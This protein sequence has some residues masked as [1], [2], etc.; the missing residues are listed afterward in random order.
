MFVK[1]NGD[2]IGPDVYSTTV[3]SSSVINGYTVMHCKATATGFSA[4]YALK[5]HQTNPAYAGD[6]NCMEILAQADPNDRNDPNYVPV[7]NFIPGII[8]AN[9][10]KQ[11]Y[12]GQRDV[13]PFPGN[14]GVPPLIY[15][16][17]GA[18]Y[19]YGFFDCDWTD[20]S[21]ITHSLNPK[22]NFLVNNPP[23]SSYS[24]YD[25]LSNGSRPL[26]KERYVIHASANMWKAFGLMTNNPSTYRDEL[27]N[28]VFFDDW[29]ASFEIGKF[30]LNWLK[31][32][33]A[34]KMN[35]Y[36]VVEGW[37]SGGFDD[38]DPDSYRIPDHNQPARQFGTKNQ[39]LQYITSG[40]NAG[41][42]GLRCNY[43][44]AA[45]NSWSIQ[46]G[47]V[48]K[49]LNSN[50]VPQ[51]FTDFNSVEPLVSSQEGDI[52]TDFN[53]TAVFHD[54]W[55][56]GTPVNLNANWIGAEC[57]SAT[58]RQTI[59]RICQSAK[60]THGGPMGSESLFMEYLLGEYVD[61]GDFDVMNADTRY[62][63]VPEYKLYRLHQ[64]S[65]FHGMGL[66]HRFFTGVDDIEAGN[67]SYFMDD[68]KLDGYRACEVLYGNGGYLFSCAYPRYGLREIHALTE[69]FT[70][71]VVQRYYALQQLDYMQYGKAGQWKT[72]DQ[73]ITSSSTLADVQSWFK[74]FHVRYTNGCHVWVNRDTSNLA[75]TLPDSN[76]VTLPQNGWLV[77]TEDCNVVAYTALSA[78][79]DPDPN[80]RVDFCND[81]NRGI[82][83]VNPRTASSYKGVNKPTVWFNNVIHF[84]LDDSQKTFFEDYRT[85]SA[86]A[87]Y[88]GGILCS[89]DSDEA[90]IYGLELNGTDSLELHTMTG[91]GSVFRYGLGLAY[92]VV[93]GSVSGYDA[94]LETTSSSNPTLYLRGLAV[95]PTYEGSWGRAYVAAQD[96]QAEWRSRWGVDGDVGNLMWGQIGGAWTLM[97]S[98]DISLSS[99]TVLDDGIWTTSSNMVYK[100][101]Y[102]AWLS[103]N[104]YTKSFSMPKNLQ[105]VS[106]GDSNDLWLLCQDGEIL[107]ISDSTGTILD[108]FYLSASVTQPW[109][110]AYAYDGWK[111]LWI[112]NLADN[113]IYQISTVL[114]PARVPYPADSA[115]TV[116]IN[117]DAN[118][119]SGG[120]A[121][122]HDVYF[123]TNQTNVNNATH[124]SGEFKGNQTSTT[125]D[126]GMLT[127][128]TTY[129][130]RIDEVGIN[131]TR[132][133]TVWHFTTAVAPGQA[134]T[135]SPAN[136]ATNVSITPTLSWT[137]GSGTISHDVYFGTTSPGTFKG[138]Q[139]GATYVPGTLVNN[140]TYY[141]RIDEVGPGGTT[142]GVVWSFTTIKAVSTF[143]AAGAVTSNTTAI[144]PALP[145]GIATNDILLLFL[146]T[147]NEAITIPT[148]NGGTWTAVTNSPQGTG[149][150]GSTSATRLTV[151]WS[152]YNGT[153]GAP[154]TSDSGDHQA[155][156]IIAIRGAA[157]SGNPWDVT[158]GGVE[159]VSDT[160]G[161][162]PGATTTVGNTLVVMA[163]AAALPDSTS[164]TNFA[165]WTNANLTSI[166]ERVDSAQSA[167]NGG[168]IGIATGVRAATG[169]YG[170]TAVT[171]ATSAYK[172]MMS[173]AIKP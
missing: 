12:S 36:T 94:K 20:S 42:I 49:A 137:A 116:S 56:S 60:T 69:C 57:P 9:G 133:G 158:A 117:V 114:S 143:V 58:S 68:E 154:T 148:P 164:T 147:A 87:V 167:G 146:E 104:S 149:T 64:L 7:A 73:I 85:Q 62:D 169:A 109:G 112:S 129:Y 34:D 15:W 121:M 128:N 95:V 151:F 166:T 150:A 14:Y 152:R 160:S 88:A 70:I 39:L 102:A 125:Y 159:A 86:E 110:I 103:Q 131:V 101:P 75:V 2:T 118:W 153:Q 111:S 120:Y 54:Q 140:T 161:S 124:V 6:P 33:V 144:T 83:Y 171:L 52:H 10:L 31:N 61:T 162:I 50:G 138:N 93:D 55:A 132:K 157:T 67:Y 136:S 106:L 115:T 122:S 18:V 72:F 141:W 71:G 22:S 156:R 81:K 80:K 35:S 53:T 163:I 3:L 172:G 40:K 105:G 51:W 21:W 59:R 30:T 130:W 92:A 84:V 13:D 16:P 43:M 99:R 173:I 74:K 65:T 91:D 135:P 98:G 145:A 8:Q 134:T 142:T 47:S 82:K 77:Y 45:N 32:V 37:Q 113:K 5:F 123:G 41:R 170:N 108:R 165:T 44:V 26:L 168:A 100:Y 28:M 126:P 76:V 127:A 1:S 63:F 96:N 79:G 27:K 119:V 17:T 155:G 11:F 90:S 46:E 107:R 38:C 78:A 139:A 29:G 66:G 48:K 19:L 4:T 89:F 25:K 97:M 24:V 23:L